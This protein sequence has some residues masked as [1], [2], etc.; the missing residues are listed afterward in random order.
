MDISFRVADPSKEAAQRSLNTWLVQDPEVKE[1]ATVSFES[2]GKDAMG[3][4]LEVIKLVLDTTFSLADLALAIANWRREAASVAAPL[5]AQRSG[6]STRLTLDDMDD[7]KVVHRALSGAPDPQRSRCVLIGVRDY[8]TLWPLP[9][10]EGNLLRLAEMLADPEIWGIP[11][12]R[13]HRVEY[14]QSAEDILR[15]LRNAA[16][17]A[18]DTLLVYYAGHGLY[19]E[20]KGLLLA[21]PHASEDGGQGV[22]PWQELADVIQSARAGRRVAILDCCYGGLAIDGGA[23]NPDLVNAAKAPGIY[24]I[25]AAESDGQ[26]MA[27][28]GE[29]CT[30]FTREL[31]RVLH[32]GIPPNP[33]HHEFLTLNDIAQHVRSELE[34]SGHPPAKYED[35]SGIGQRPFVHNRSKKRPPKI[36]RDRST[37]PGWWPPSHRALMAVCLV[38]AV[39]AVIAL[40]VAV[41]PGRSAHDEA[42]KHTTAVGG[43]SQTGYC[44]S[45]H[46]TVSGGYCFQRIDLNAACRWQYNKNDLKFRFTSKDL[47]SGICYHGRKVYTD[48]I[49]D[50][51]GYCAHATGVVDVVATDHSS[52][53]PRAWLCQKKIDRNVACISQ[54]K[55]PDLVARKDVN[56]NW[57]CYE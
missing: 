41:L 47:E 33:Q 35:P 3:A 40:V 25:A 28:A 32:D 56:G 20:E 26:T 10:V 57:V 37:P 13:L 45:Q 30:V 22:V 50:M 52:I 44:S 5:I 23:K 7:P 6:T 17:D 48:G 24:T 19:D 12:G 54:Y 27:P 2:P 34:S 18:P 31:V 14:P 39:L 15:V 9:A 21:L 16:A 8:A 36:R 4:E 29:E 38:V 43:L 46:M 51:P 42:S 11:Q 55:K 1:K 53:D 49:T